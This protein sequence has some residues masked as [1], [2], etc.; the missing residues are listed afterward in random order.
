A[1]RGRRR[2]R[3]APAQRAAEP[4]RDTRPAVEVAAHVAGP[5]ALA[6]AL[7][8]ELEAVA[9]FLA[10]EDAAA[11][12]H[13]R[14]ARAHRHRHRLAAE[15]D[16]ERARD[17]AVGERA[18]GLP[19]A[20]RLAVVERALAGEI[21]GVGRKRRGGERRRKRERDKRERPRGET[22]SDVHECDPLY[23]RSF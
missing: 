21:P 4:A 12:F 13:E 3:G 15:F 2:G 19:G 22:A 7:A 20:L 5:E 17:L 1:R 6:V 23:S 8:A 16:R 14:R 9:A 18:A 11:V 10:L